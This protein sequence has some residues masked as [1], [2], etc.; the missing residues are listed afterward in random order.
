MTLASSVRVAM[1]FAALALGAC[2]TPPAAQAWHT[3]QVAPGVHVYTGPHEDLLRS[4]L[5]A[6]SN[7]SFIVGERCVAV[8]DTGGS[9]VAGERLREAVRKVTDLKVCY[10]INTHAH[11]DHSMGNAAFLDDKPEFVGHAKAPA[12]FATRGPHYRAAVLRELAPES[13]GTELVPPTLTVTDKRTLDLG[14]RSIDITAWPTSHTDHDVTV[15]DGKTQTLFTGDLLFIGH[16]PAVDGSLRGWLTTLRTLKTINAKHVVPGHG[17]VQ[18]GWN[19]TWAA[20]VRYL[21]VLLNETRAAI[22][23]QDSIQKAV[24]TV[25]QSERVHWKLF[26][27]F[28]RRNVTAAYA[29]LEWE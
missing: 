13:A 1:L 19:E 4:N 18:S 3:V 15:F 28:H 22:K 16:V 14:S 29:E 21:E 9:R 27:L 7:L 17:A 6:I 26:D 8:I 25:G 12:A 10:V 24:S 20:H 5:G 2:A 11:P 23:R